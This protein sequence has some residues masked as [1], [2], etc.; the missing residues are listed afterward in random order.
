MPLFDGSFSFIVADNVHAAILSLEYM[1][2]IWRIEGTAGRLN[3][4]D[5]QIVCSIVDRRDGRRCINCKNEEGPLDHHHVV[6]ISAG[7]TNRLTNI[8]IVCR[9]CHSKIHPWMKE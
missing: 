8:R 7:G 6:P 3:D 4:D 9:E 5:W 1:A 2:N